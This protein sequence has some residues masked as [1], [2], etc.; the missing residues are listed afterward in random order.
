MHK[1]KYIIR[2]SEISTSFLYENWDDKM[3]CDLAAPQQWKL[4]FHLVYFLIPFYS[5]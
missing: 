1:M 4:P 5:L 2:V 3:R